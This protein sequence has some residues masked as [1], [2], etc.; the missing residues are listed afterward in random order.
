[1]RIARP[2]RNLPVPGFTQPVRASDG[3]GN[4]AAQT[5]VALALP[6]GA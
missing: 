3:S 6:G 1:M 4:G 5:Q 2:G